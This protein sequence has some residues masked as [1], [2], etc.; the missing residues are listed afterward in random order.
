MG[1]Q[2]EETIHNEDSHFE[3][4][5]KSPLMVCVDHREKFIHIEIEAS[6]DVS[7]VNVRSL[8]ELETLTKILNR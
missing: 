5:R 1:F 2:H 3:D 8:Q 4:W 6:N 7:K